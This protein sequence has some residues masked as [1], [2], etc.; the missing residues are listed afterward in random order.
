MIEKLKLLAIPLEVGTK[1]KLKRCPFCGGSNLVKLI[2]Y[3][4]DDI[5][6]FS[7]KY[8]V[9]CLYTGDKYGCG[10]QG[11]QNKSLEAAV[12]AWNLRRLKNK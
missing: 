4:A 6:R 12:D 10:A 11:Q 7:D 3:K 9:Q 1:I 2:V 8:A 5:T